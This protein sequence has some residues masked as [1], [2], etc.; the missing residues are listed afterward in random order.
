MNTTSTYAPSVTAVDSHAHVF[1]CADA[2]VDHEYTPTAD[3]TV[4]TYLKHLDTHGFSHGVLAQ[5]S[6]LGEDH[7]RLLHALRRHPARLRGIAAIGPDTA[8]HAME[9]LVAAGVV[10]TRLNLISRSRDALPDLSSARWRA[11]LRVAAHR[12]W[13]VQVH[14]RAQA[15]PALL[16]PLLD[17]GLRVVVDHFG[18]PAP[19]LGVTDPAFGELLAFGATRQVWVKLSAAYRCDETMPGDGFAAAAVPM[20]LDAYGPDRLLWGSDWPHTRF[21]HDPRLNYDVVAARVPRWLRHIEARDGVLR[22]GP[23]RLFRL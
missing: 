16:P 23:A 4:E 5:P 2:A 14:C 10:G 9:E 13:H 7:S 21:Q 22:S 8:A 3:A 6:F 19:G 18:R 1:H 11:F 12:N 20:L 17:Q 15:L